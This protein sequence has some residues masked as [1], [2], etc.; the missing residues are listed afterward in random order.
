MQHLIITIEK[1]KKDLADLVETYGMT[2][3]EAIKCSQ[4]LDS[5]IHL[6]LTTAEKKEQSR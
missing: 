6:L 5:L 1:Y 3:P 4:E 2:S